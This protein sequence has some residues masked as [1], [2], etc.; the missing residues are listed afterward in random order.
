MIHTELGRILAVA[1]GGGA[2]QRLHLGWLNRTQLRLGAEL[3]VL[4]SG[5]CCTLQQLSLSGGSGTLYLAGVPLHLLRGLQRLTLKGAAK[6]DSSTQLPPSVTHL[7]LDKVSADNRTRL[8]PQVSKRMRHLELACWGDWEPLR[9]GKAGTPRLPIQIAW[10]KRGCKDAR[11]QC[12]D[13]NHRA[14]QP[15]CCVACMHE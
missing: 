2:L 7:E 3:A 6:W 15:E 1:C 12:K 13:A 8:P 10:C 9:W 14:N 11:G 4:G 5:G